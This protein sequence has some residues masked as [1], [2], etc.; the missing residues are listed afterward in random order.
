MSKRNIYKIATVCFW[1]YLGLSV[2]A[3]LKEVFLTP[4]WIQIVTQYSTLE[5][6]IECS[7]YIIG[8]SCFKKSTI[9]FNIFRI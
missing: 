5:I 7:I 8:R 6:I 9:Y 4:N 1:G 2:I 3:V